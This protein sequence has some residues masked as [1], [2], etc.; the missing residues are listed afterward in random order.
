MRNRFR[1]FILPILPSHADASADMPGM[2][3]SPRRPTQREQEYPVEELHPS[4]QRK[5]Y[6]S[7]LG[8]GEGRS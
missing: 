5:R 7:S 4:P 2:T 3:R 6:L 8:S 1:K